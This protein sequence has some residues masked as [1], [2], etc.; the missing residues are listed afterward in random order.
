MIAP[1][2]SIASTGVQSATP[3]PRLVSAAHEFEAQLMK[4]LLKPMNQAF[5]SHLDGDD[6]EDDDGGVLG[7]Y[8]TES[9]ARALSNQGGLGIADRI[10]RNLS[11]ASNTQK[12]MP[13]TGDLR[14]DTVTSQLK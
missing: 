14:V 8:A 3:Q 13:V 10:I 4:E 5:S 2:T 7:E 12:T 9:L 11:S 6:S 1:V